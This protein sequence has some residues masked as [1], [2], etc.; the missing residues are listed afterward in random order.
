MC[1]GTERL[2]VLSGSQYAVHDEDGA[3]HM[4]AAYLYER[5]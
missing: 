1:I 5:D 4:D 2:T 3:R